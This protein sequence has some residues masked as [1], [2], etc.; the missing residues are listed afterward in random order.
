MI[1]LALET[2]SPQGS[3]ALAEISADGA[4]R[5]LGERHWQREKSHS[6]LLTVHLQELLKSNG[7]SFN[8]LDA[9]FTGIGP[10]SFTGVR[11][12]ASFARALGFSLG[13]PVWP[14]NTLKVWAA[15]EISTAN[16][17]LVVMRGFRDIVYIAVYGRDQSRAQEILSPLA[18]QVKDLCHHLPPGPLTV[19]GDGWTTFQD[20]WPVE[21]KERVKVFTNS[22]PE[23]RS[24]FSIFV[25]ERPLLEKHTWQSVKPLYIRGSEAEEKLRQG[26]LK[27]V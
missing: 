14:V 22:F 18:V 25:E 4:F 16:P 8:Q 23:A 15:S 17:A 1:A 20:L 24:L 26:L 10:G 13:V 5:L 3:L 27:P 7:L 9:I 6:E 2:C 21:L 12:G 19:L 11:I